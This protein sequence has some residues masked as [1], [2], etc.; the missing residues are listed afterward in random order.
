MWKWP[1]SN[2]GK[3]N[4]PAARTDATAPSN[5]HAVEYTEVTR[6]V[7][8]FRAAIDAE[9]ERTADASVS[10][11][12]DKGADADWK[13]QSVSERPSAPESSI[14]VKSSVAPKQF[15]PESIAPH[16]AGLPKAESPGDERRRD[17]S[18][19]AKLSDSQ[20][21]RTESSKVNSRSENPPARES[22][23]G[24]G[25][26]SGIGF[27]APG[28]AKQVEATALASG[29]KAGEV[30]SGD[31]LVGELHAGDINAADVKPDELK[32]GD[33]KNG[34]AERELSTNR[35]SA[36]AKSISDW[37]REGEELYSASLKEY[38]E[39]EAQ[40]A[41]LEQ[42]LQAKQAEVNQIAHIIGKPPVEGNRRLAAELLDNQNHGVPNSP[43]TIARALAGRQFNR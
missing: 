1:I 27:G 37:M 13:N 6:R 39:L 4:P 36:V 19:G 2:T 30:I 3:E 17:E 43:A 40:L 8:A 14:D 24:A 20:L 16:A 42:R 23:W 11:G 33:V 25:V 31:V 28:D 29:V 12:D 7:S 21:P 10:P 38:Q 9:R 5:V 35:G 41:D 22:V 18:S 26:L 15:S 32:S 34:D